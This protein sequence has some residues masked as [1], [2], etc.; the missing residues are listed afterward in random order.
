VT[1]EPEEDFLQWS[2]TTRT[3][4]AD[5]LDADGDHLPIVSKPNW[6]MEHR[7]EDIN[8]AQKLGTIET[9]ADGTSARL[10]TFDQPGTITITV[11]ASVAP[12]A[13]ASKTFTVAV[14]RHPPVT[15][16]LPTFR[17]TQSRNGS[18]HH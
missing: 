16:R 9:S 1:T 3:Y 15:T 8:V 2:S 11:S 6:T 18:I 10:T 12:T 5:H 13:F 17:V 4:H 7:A 14:K